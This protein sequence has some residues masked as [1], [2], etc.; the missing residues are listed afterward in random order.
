MTHTSGIPDHFSLG[1][2]KPDLKNSDVLAALIKQKKLNFKPGEKYSYSNGAYVLL[3]MIVEKASGVPFHK[4]MKNNL[5]NPLGMNNT[6]VFDESKPVIKNR[7]AGSNI[8]EELNDYNILTTGAGGIFS[9]VEDLFLW[10]QALYTEKLVS[11]QTIK[12]AFTPTVLNDGSLSYYGFG[13]AISKDTTNK[14]VSHGG[15]LSGYRTFIY[16][17]ITNKNACIFL[18]NKGNAVNLGEIRR[19]IQN[20]LD[21]TPYSLP[22]IPISSKLI[23]QLKNGNIDTA[24]KLTRNLLENQ[25]DKYKID[26]SGINSMGYKYISEKKLKAAI[27]IFKFNIELSPSSSNVYDSQ[28]EAYLLNGDSA[29]AISN[30]KKSIQL[31]PANKN[32]LKMLTKMGVD[33]AKLIPKITIPTEVLDKYVG[34]YELSP[35]FIITIS[36][37]QEQLIAQATGQP[38]SKVFPASKTRFYFK[39]VNAQI[40]FNMDDTGKISSLTLHQRG[41]S[42]AKKIE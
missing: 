30:Y 14:S 20:I 19:T 18:T 32:G 39:V 21:N 2:Y 29:L 41:E 17:D 42:V 16:R 13:W 33:V 8:M 6:L 36:R 34:K 26:E 31:N 10:D 25:P 12:D 9:T 23:S 22:K 27:A 38:S 40:T 35:K 28:G 37:N 1:I 5:F 7:A 15:S 4:Y 11:Y 3:A 24:I